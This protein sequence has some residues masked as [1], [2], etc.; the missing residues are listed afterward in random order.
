MI[1]SKKSKMGLEIANYMCYTQYINEENSFFQI[2][3]K[4]RKKK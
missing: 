2:S 1:L 3:K 4:K